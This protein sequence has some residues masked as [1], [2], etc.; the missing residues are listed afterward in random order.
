LTERHQFRKDFTPEQYK[1][2]LERVAKTSK[3]EYDGLEPWEIKEGAKEGFERHP[4]K[5]KKKVS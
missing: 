4:N 1:A 2:Y 3:Y 5:S